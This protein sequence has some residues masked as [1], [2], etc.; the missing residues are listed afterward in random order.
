MHSAHILPPDSPASQRLQ[1]D[2]NHRQWNAVRPP[3]DGRTDSR[4]MLM[5]DWLPI[6]HYLFYLVGSCLYLLINIFVMWIYLEVCLGKRFGML[7]NIDSSCYIFHLLI[8]RRLFI[9]KMSLSNIVT[10]FRGSVCRRR[11]HSR[12]KLITVCS[13][14]TKFF[15]EQ[16][17]WEDYAED[18]RDQLIFKGG[19]ANSYIFG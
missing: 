11:T 1:R 12:T 13:I 2:R 7:R 18:G 14:K 19:I 8:E 4:N 3:D 10:G 17:F 15:P 9:R 6:N 5:N 16:T